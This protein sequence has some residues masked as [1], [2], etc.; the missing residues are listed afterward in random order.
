MARTTLAS[1]EPP[2]AE[3]PGSVVAVLGLGLLGGIA[4]ATAWLLA[5]GTAWGALAAYGAGGV[6]G[7]L[8]G[9]WLNAT[10]ERRRR[11][12]LARRPDGAKGVRD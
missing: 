4:G 6:P 2:G 1:P 11:A 9:A 12:R 10:L 7:M 3:G 8:A 5:G